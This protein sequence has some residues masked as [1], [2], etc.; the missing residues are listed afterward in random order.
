MQLFLVFQKYNDFVVFPMHIFAVCCIAKV[1]K[2]LINHTVS[3]VF[4]KA[5]R[6]RRRR[7]K[8]PSHFLRWREGRVLVY[9]KKNKKVGRD[10]DSYDLEFPVWVALEAAMAKGSSIND[11]IF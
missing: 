3:A 4:C 8:K 6:Q 11:I 9:H 10:S 5:A 2:F 1:H 7:A